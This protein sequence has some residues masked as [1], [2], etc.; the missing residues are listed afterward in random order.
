MNII[1]LGLPGAGKGTQAKLIVDNLSIPHISTGDLFRKAEQEGTTLG[2]LAQEYMSKGELVPDDVTIGIALS[3][4]GEADCQRG[5]LLDGFPRSLAQAEALDAYLQSNSKHIDHVIY[6]KIDENLLFERLTGRR[7]CMNC[8]AA[9]HLRYNPPVNQDVCDA[10]NHTLIQRDDDREETVKER[11]RVN[12]ELTD[13]LTN[14]YS[15]TGLLRV[16]DGSQEIG[17]VSE[18]ILNII[19]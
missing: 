16:V 2:L 9:Y 11:L 4:L 3:R 6:V 17:R 5:F 10:C 13:M 18:S 12:R 7:V 15:K 8:G 1:L 19:S 14:Y